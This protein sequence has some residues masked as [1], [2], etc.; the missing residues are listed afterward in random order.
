MKSR[1]PALILREQ[2]RGANAEIKKRRRLAKRAK[3]TGLEPNHPYNG[4]TLL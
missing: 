1:P 2:I 3:R 4:K